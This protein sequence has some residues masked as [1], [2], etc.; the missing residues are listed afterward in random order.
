[1][2]P[3]QIEPRLGDARAV[4]SA[5]PRCSVAV[6]AVLLHEQLLSLLCI[7]RGSGLRRR[8]DRRRYHD[9]Q[10]YVFHSRSYLGC[11]TTSTSAGSPRLTTS[12]AFFNAGPRSAG[13][14][15]GPIPYIPYAFAMVA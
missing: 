15:I 1:H 7:S 11:E 10:E 4:T 12:I 13:F 9:N 8:E 6:V 2:D 5:L 14:S 3:L